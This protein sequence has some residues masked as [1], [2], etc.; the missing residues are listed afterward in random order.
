[1]NRMDAMCGGL[2]SLTVG[3]SRITVACLALAGPVLACDTPV[4][5][6]ALLH[7]PQDDTVVYYLHRGAE[8]STDA[9]V[10]AL[11]GRVAADQEGHANVTFVRVDGRRAEGQT[12]DA[13]RALEL[14]GDEP[15]PRH[16]VVS[17]KGRVLLSGRMTVAD[18]R[19]LLQS[20]KTATLADILARGAQGTLV[21]L[22]DDD[23]ERNG[24]ARDAVR[25]AIQTAKAAG[26]RVGML[27]LSRQDWRER[28]LV[29]QLLAVEADLT[30]LGGPMVFGVYG[31]G[32]ATEAYVGR[33]INAA[34]LA[35]LIGFMNG[36]C[37]CDIRAAGLGVDLVTNRDWG[38][39]APGPAL[40]L[41]ATDPGG[42]VTFGD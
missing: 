25:A 18:V 5:E 38:D 24:G 32:H 29:R 11:L 6:Y 7:W 13:R 28:W 40:G 26:R 41:G 19:D 30:E 12:P 35:N 16:V 37:T 23:A 2:R 31:R 36:L 20:P 15:L 42:Y 8:G 33:G 22:T 39:P 10:N 34:N 17:P 27:E 3:V 14:A 9:E 21:L 1:M 4:Y